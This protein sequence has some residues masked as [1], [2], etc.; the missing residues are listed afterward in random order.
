[1]ILVGVGVGLILRHTRFD[2]VGGLIVAVTVG[3]MVGGLLSAGFASTP[4]AGFCGSDDGRI[5]F[6]SRDGTFAASSVELRL[7]CGQMTVEAAPGNAWHVRGHPDNGRGPAIYSTTC[8]SASGP[9]RTAL[10]S[11]GSGRV[12]P[13]ILWS[14]DAARMDVDLQVN[15]GGATGPSSA[16]RRWA[17]STSSRTQALPPSTDHVTS[18]GRFDATLNAGSLGVRLP[19]VSVIGAIGAN[20]GAVRLRAP[21]GAA[22]K[23]RTGENHL[24]RRDDYDGHGLIKDGSDVDD[25]GLRYGRVNIRTADLLPMRGPSPSIPQD[26]PATPRLYR[27]RDDRNLSASPAA[28]PTRS[29][30]DPSLVRAPWVILAFLAPAASRPSSTS[31]WRSSVPEAPAGTMPGAR[32]GPC[33]RV[34]RRL[35]RPAAVR[36]GVTRRRPCR[37]LPGHRRDPGDRSGHSSSS[38]AACSASAALPRLR[39]AVADR[40]HR[41]RGPADHPAPSLGRRATRAD[42]PVLYHGPRGCRKLSL[43]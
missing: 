7:D 12:T 5:A 38:S 17:Q 30:T 16:A 41:A 40:R 21:A 11:S 37:P 8:S 36:P 4:R 18:I 35:V 43:R 2:F 6:P 31:S 15:A 9:P 25:A 3:R 27:S 20:A 32:H 26:G 22:L 28:S 23:L 24:V 34:G 10:R 29:H 39:P 13:G 33:R 1:M 14:P 42:G 19:N